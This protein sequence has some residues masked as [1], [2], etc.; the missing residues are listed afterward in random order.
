MF[1]RCSLAHIYKLQ[2]PKSWLRYMPIPTEVITSFLLL[3]A[4]ELVPPEKEDPF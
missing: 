3:L 1:L 4:C 2:I